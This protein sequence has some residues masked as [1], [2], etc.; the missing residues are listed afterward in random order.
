VW[1]K[2][3]RAVEDPASESARKHFIRRMNEVTQHLELVFHRY[4]AGEA[5]L[6]RVSIL[7][8][9]LALKPFDPFFSTH[10]ATIRGQLEK[11]KLA[12]GTVE[13]TAFTLPHH[14]N[15]TPAEWDRYGGS[16]GY[17][18]NQGFYLYRE[19]RLIV[20]GTWFGLARQM[21]LTKLTRVRIDMPNSLDEEWQVDV[22]KAWARPPL[23]V[24]ER[25]QRIIAEIGAPSRTIFTKR[26]ARLHD[27]RCA[28]WQRVRENNAIVYRVNPEHPVL[29][30]FRGR[31]P[32]G[33]QDDFT[34]VL[35]G[36]GA[37]IPM[38]AIFADLAG[39][40]ESVKN[41][42]L[43]DDSLRS[44]VAVTYGKLVAS[45]ID[46]ELIPHMLKSAEP[47]RSDWERTEMILADLTEGASN[48]L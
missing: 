34:R 17:L 15:V 10:A 16:A 40:P 18:K 29:E 12:E 8:N 26:G 4:L 9:G 31:L 21:E 25:L 42:A 35:E 44:L 43:S 2:L 45:G 48:E 27:S 37:A 41:D 30:G 46:R 3:D 13:I 7:L 11:V 23:Q 32:Q 20:H 6:K 28:L 33:L 36:I 1:E 38:D 24:R 22:K 47:F 39:S 14:R 19:R 5:P